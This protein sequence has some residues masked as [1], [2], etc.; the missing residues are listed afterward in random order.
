[1][2][3]ID[4]TCRILPRRSLCE[5]NKNQ[6]HMFDLVQLPKELAAICILYSVLPWKYV[7]DL[8]LS[9]DSTVLAIIDKQISLK[10]LFTVPQVCKSWNQ[11]WQ[12]ESFGAILWNKLFEVLFWKYDT[13]ND[14]SNWRTVLVESYQRLHLISLSMRYLQ[15]IW[16][17]HIYAYEV[18]DLL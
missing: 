12:N 2:N 14:T 8:D 18:P 7:D 17:Q 9:K 13:Q 3:E 5:R 15:A 4:W 11:L 6:Q 16:L 10:S 1:M